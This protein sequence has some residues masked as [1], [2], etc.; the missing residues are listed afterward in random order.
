MADF[1]LAP[2]AERD[3]FEIAL[4]GLENFGPVQ[5]EQYRDGLKSR[6]QEI[7]NSPLRY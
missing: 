1:K 4:Y 6:F 3:L 5:S 2:E 7:A